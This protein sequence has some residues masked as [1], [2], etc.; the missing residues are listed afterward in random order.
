MEETCLLLCVCVINIVCTNI[1]IFYFHKF[2]YDKFINNIK[3]ITKN[4][5][6]LINAKFKNLFPLSFSFP[7]K[8][9]EKIK[10]INSKIFEFSDNLYENENIFAITKSNNI[11]DLTSYIIRIEKKDKKII[12]YHRFENL[13]IKFLFF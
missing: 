4:L 12:C 7:I 9:C 5:L 13:D 8:F 3:S 10:V 1:C 11:I 6:P 2:Y